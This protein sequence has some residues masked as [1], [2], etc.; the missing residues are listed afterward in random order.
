M[1]LTSTQ[2]SQAITSSR[3]RVVSC[4]QCA[5]SMPTVE[6]ESVCSTPLGMLDS[7]ACPLRNVGIRGVGATASCSPHSLATPCI[8][9]W[10][11]S[12]VSVFNSGP[13]RGIS[14]EACFS[15]R[16][17]LPTTSLFNVQC[18][19]LT[20]HITPP[21]VQSNQL[22]SPSHFLLFTPLKYTTIAPHPSPSTLMQI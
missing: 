11:F 17:C 3:S 5:S 20:H 7:D 9:A 6:V 22:S 10:P 19:H 13:V 21:Q 15:W 2:S 18:K 16:I 1:N 12:F 14:R 8:C 4:W